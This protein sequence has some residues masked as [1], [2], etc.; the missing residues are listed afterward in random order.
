MGLLSGLLCFDL[1]LLTH[2]HNIPAYK[3]SLA[4]DLLSLQDMG[5]IFEH[6][7]PDDGHA[8]PSPTASPPLSASSLDEK[9][10]ANDSSIPSTPT[11]LSRVGTSKKLGGAAPSI[12]SSTPRYFAFTY[13]FIRDAIYQVTPSFV[14][15]L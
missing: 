13:G 5:F 10:F 3:A 11:P 6:K 14:S 4:G 15:M 9:K 12:D 7:V 8:P 2:I 1:T